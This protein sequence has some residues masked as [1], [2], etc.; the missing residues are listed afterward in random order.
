MSQFI[1]RRGAWCEEPRRESFLLML[2]LW[3]QI[4]GVS[5]GASVIKIQNFQ[6][7]F[8]GEGDMVAPGPICTHLTAV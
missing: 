8:I 4:Q 5:Q 2:L 1:G 7:I 6:V 3:P